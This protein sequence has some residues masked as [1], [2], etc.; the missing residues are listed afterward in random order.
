MEGNASEMLTNDSINITAFSKKTTKPQGQHPHIMFNS[1]IK[2]LAFHR[3]IK[4]HQSSSPALIIIQKTNSKVLSSPKSPRPS[5][6][7]LT[8]RQC[9]PIIYGWWIIEDY[10]GDKHVRKLRN[11]KVKATRS[12]VQGE[13]CCEIPFQRPRAISGQ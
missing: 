10:N 8:S 12:L 9:N 4:T 6:P 5:D 1:A 11:Q 13:I 3:P 2:S 7:F